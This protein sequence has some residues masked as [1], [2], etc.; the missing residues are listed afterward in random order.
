MT[1]ARKLVRGIVWTVLAQ[2]SQTVGSMVTAAMINRA[3]SPAGRGIIADVQTW[4]GLLVTLFGLSLNSA[5]Y[6]CANRER[7]TY[8]DDTR[9]Y[10]VL[11]TSTCASIVAT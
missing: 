11:L 8:G 9:L 2:G 1:T 3:I 7:Y 6:H 10:I 5:I 4:A